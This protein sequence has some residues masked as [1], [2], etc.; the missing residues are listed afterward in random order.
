MRVLPT[1]YVDAFPNVRSFSFGQTVPYRS[2][3]KKQIT[4]CVLCNANLK[5]CYGLIT[6]TRLCRR[7]GAVITRLRTVL[8]STQ[9]EFLHIHLIN[10]K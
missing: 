6:R 7:C 2:S 3:G 1:L 4:L 5:S 8:K 9:S 10:C